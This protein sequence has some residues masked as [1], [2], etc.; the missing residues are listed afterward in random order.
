MGHLLETLLPTEAHLTQNHP[1]PLN[2]SVPPAASPQTTS[3]PSKTAPSS[4]R[5][6]LDRAKTQ[7]SQASNSVLNNY[8]LPFI[9]FFSP[10]HLYLA[11]GS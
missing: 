2:P 4:P 10:D 7:F 5:P 8:F 9:Y 1:V 11:A 3:S 6:Y